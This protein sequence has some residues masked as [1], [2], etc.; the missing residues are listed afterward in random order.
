VKRILLADDSAVIRT[1]LRGLF[2]E[3]GWT[4]S[5]AENGEDAV[6]KAQE[7]RPHVIVLDLAMPGMN[8]IAAASALK[9]VLPPIP[10]I[11]FTSFGSILNS[12]DLCRAGISAMIGKDDA[13][14]LLSTAQ[15]LFD[16]S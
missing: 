10:V 2:E 3:S 12:E 15:T 11:V 13:A 5:E 9:T 6:A 7:F 1:T 16:H 14:K 8:G 4:C